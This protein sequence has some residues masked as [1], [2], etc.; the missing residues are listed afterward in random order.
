MASDMAKGKDLKGKGPTGPLTAVKP[1]KIPK[2]KLA[3]TSNTTRNV[4]KSFTHVASSNATGSDK[5]RNHL[6]IGTRGFQPAVRTGVWGLG[7]WHAE[8]KLQRNQGA[9]GSTSTLGHLWGR[10]V[11]LLS[12]KS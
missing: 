8:Q 5:N 6:G 4:Q 1:P 7:R 10:A 2:T 3:S 9:T 11:G 12:R